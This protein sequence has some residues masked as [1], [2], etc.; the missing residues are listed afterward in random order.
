[1]AR[2]TGC[3]HS[4]AGARSVFCGMVR[5]VER[6]RSDR[7]H[8]A[9]Q[10]RI[11]GGCQVHITQQRRA[12]TTARLTD[13]TRAAPPSH[14]EVLQK[15]ETLFIERED[16][17]RASASALHRA[18]SCPR[19]EFWGA[20]GISAPMRRALAADQIPR[21]CSRLGCHFWFRPCKKQN[22]LC[23][24]LRCSLCARA[25][26]PGPTSA[27]PTENSEEAR[28]WNLPESGDF[29][30]CC[31]VCQQKHLQGSLFSI[32]CLARDPGPCPDRKLTPLR[33]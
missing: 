18:R 2:P 14:E 16:V 30:L 10:K 5:T 19:P 26:V 25:W 7:L 11:A 21:G 20:F 9:I 31:Y 33:G 15:L 1:M 8:Q 3:A 12:D 13:T 22:N 6:K 29:G 4:Y 17:G 23:I 28:P 24:R 27:D 32:S